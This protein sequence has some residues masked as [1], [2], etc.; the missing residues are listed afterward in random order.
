VVEAIRDEHQR[1]RG[2]GLSDCLKKKKKE[3]LSG[4]CSPTEEIGGNN[5][6][7]PLDSRTGNKVEILKSWERKSR[8]LF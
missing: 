5:T 1:T 3:K 6:P 7:Q 2:D 8:S 4:L